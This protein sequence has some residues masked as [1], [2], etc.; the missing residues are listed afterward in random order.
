MLR[1][2]GTLPEFETDGVEPYQY[3]FIAGTAAINLVFSGIKG[4]RNEFRLGAPMHAIHKGAH[5]VD[6]CS[7]GPAQWHGEP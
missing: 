3:V 4:E 7:A 6:S 2:E 5:V 1:R